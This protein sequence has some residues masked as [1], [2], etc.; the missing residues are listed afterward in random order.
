M[1]KPK[2]QSLSAK[3]SESFSNLSDREKKMVMAMAA[4]LPIL[5]MALVLGIFN[6]SL[7]TIETNTRQYQQALDYLAMAGPEFAEKKSASQNQSGPAAYFTDEVLEDNELKLRTFLL[8]QASTA[9]I[10]ISSLDSEEIPIGSK[11]GDKSG[12]IILEKRM[13]VDIRDAKH[14][15]LLKFLEEIETSGEPVVIKRIDMR[16]KRRQ[17]GEIRARVEVSTYVKQEQES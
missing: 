17:P 1:A 3:L 8:T 13:K 16:G 14:Q 5:A 7:D 10:K 4:V 9:G 12:P 11:S 15:D 6:R 2:K